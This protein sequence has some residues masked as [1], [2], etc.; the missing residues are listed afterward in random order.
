MKNIK[1]TVAYFMVLSLLTTSFF[2]DDKVFVVSDVVVAAENSN[3]TENVTQKIDENVET[4]PEI[5]GEEITTKNENLAD[6]E[7]TVEG[8]S[9]S[10]GETTTENENSSDGETTTEDKSSSEGETTTESESSSEEETTTEYI[11]INEVYKVKDTTLVEYLGDKNDSTVTDI[12]IPAQVTAIADSVFA[13]SPYIKKVSFEAGSS[14]LTLGEYVFS[15]C[16][17][18]ET[19]ELPEGI[20]DLGYR[21]FAKSMSIKELYIPTT[22]T[23]GRQIL[24]KNSAVTYVRFKKGMV[25]IPKAILRYAS[26]VQQVQMYSGITSIGEYAFEGCTSLTTINLPD[27]ILSIRM[28]A[29]KNCS[30]ISNLTLPSGL[31][32]IGEE[33]FRGC[34]FLA[35]LKIKNTVKS[36]GLNAFADNP[37]LI[38]QLYANSYA[39]RYAIQYELN[40]EY[41]PSELVRQ[42]KSQDITAIMEGL[43]SQEDLNKYQL[44]CLKNYVPQGV[45]VIK[46]FVV[47]SMYHKNM[48]KKSILLV[49]KR[50]T[51]EYIKKVKLPSIDHVGAVTNVENRLVVSLNNISATDYLGV[52]NYKALKKAKNGKVLNYNYKIKIPGYADFSS[53]DGKYF[54]AGRSANVSNAS[55]YGYKVKI[56]KK[57]LTFTKKYSFVVP[58]NTQGMIAIKGNGG[59]RQFILTQSYGRLPDSYI[60][61]YNINV[62]KVTEL[63][64]P[65]TTRLAP[66]MIQ[67]IAKY[68]KYVYIGFE[69]AAGKY[70]EDANNTSEI[71]M[72]SIVR[73]KYSDLASLYAET[74]QTK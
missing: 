28:A 25:S 50:S 31:I 15:D 38:L 13:T 59:N 23:T 62:N 19:V 18:L 29:F 48:S 4:T 55:M 10:D 69:S 22:V 42:Q 24:G 73:I 8:E 64:Q 66:S 39:K 46:N 2:L 5:S 51:G 41:A 53:Y 12:I 21:T 61:T 6:E 20:I 14:I 3:N 17:A 32:S 1:K 52:I 9:P 54:W 63:G 44:K 16:A 43:I 70:C 65:A 72:K 35:N 27:S 58:A 71:Q 34:T 49:Y 7:T 67:G 56:K 36:I 26:S 40:W 74:Q 11:I 37:S 57:K 45:A 60:Y 47:V 68:K 33:T 30:S